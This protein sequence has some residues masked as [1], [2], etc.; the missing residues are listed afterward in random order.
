V[1]TFW[2]P[3]EI[4]RKFI[5]SK[6]PNLQEFGIATALQQGYLAEDGPVE[7]RLRRTAN[8]E[9]LTVKTGSGLARSE[10]ELP[11]TPEQAN[12]LWPYTAERRIEKTRYRAE[13][14]DSARH[15]VEI[16]VY[17]AA[18]TGLCVIEV[19]FETSAEAAEFVPP[20]WFGREVTGEQ[21]WSNASL[22]QHGLPE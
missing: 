1:H 21:G 10:V 20:E 7:V 8:A 18:L 17:G 3:Q 4:E 12:A 22:A 16:D 13:L 19:E 15:I 5:P 2:V 9:T 11:L 6:V 14:R